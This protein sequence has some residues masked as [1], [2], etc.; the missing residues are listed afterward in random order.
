MYL[1]ASRI[2]KSHFMFL[3]FSN[4]K[5]EINIKRDKLNNFCSKQ[6]F[7]REILQENFSFTPKWSEKSD[8][9]FSVNRAIFLF[10]VLSHTQLSSKFE[11]RFSMKWFITIVYSLKSWFPTYLLFFSSTLLNSSIF[12]FVNHMHQ[13]L[14]IHY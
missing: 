1:N 3:G 11:N 4:R 2:L 14:S 6:E 10:S 13:W 5:N 12:Y 7:L 9:F 8:P